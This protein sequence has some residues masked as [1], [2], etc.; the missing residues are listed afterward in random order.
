MPI[1]LNFEIS[2]QISVFFAV[3]TV[4]ASNF[5]KTTRPYWKVQFQNGLF[6]D[7]DPYE[8]EFH[9]EPLYPVYAPACRRPFNFQV[10]ATDC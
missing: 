1:S 9:P 2:H 6:V 7:I 3:Y 4:F 10:Y 8:R 5:R